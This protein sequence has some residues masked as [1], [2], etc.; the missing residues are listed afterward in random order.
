MYAAVQARY[1]LVAG[2]QSAQCDVDDENLATVGRLP[3][4]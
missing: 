1:A 2:I 3:L 4:T